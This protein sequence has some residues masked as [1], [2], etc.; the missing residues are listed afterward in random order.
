[1]TNYNSHI[2][3]YIDEVIEYLKVK[4]DGIYIDC[5]LG[6][7]GHTKKII[8][9][10]KSG[11]VIGIDRDLDA[12]NYAKSLALTNLKIIHDKFSN[13]ESIFKNNNLN[14]VDGFLFDLGV[15]S[16]QLDDPSR[17][18]SY[19]KD[20]LLDM[21]MDQTQTMT[22]RD[23]VNNYSLNQLTKIFRLY[24]ESK[25]SY[26]VAK[27]IVNA[28]KLS[29]INTT[30]QLNEIIKSSL[31]RNELIKDKHPSRV[32]F[33]AIR[34][35]VN[36]ELEEIE[37][38]VEFA[39]KHVKKGGRVVIISFHSLEN[40]LINKIIKNVS[41]HNESLSYLPTPQKISPTFKIIKHKEL[42]NKDNLRAR[43]AR[44]HIIERDY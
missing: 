32:F 36:N 23:V 31:P 30:F 5:T 20:S 7:C 37:R 12:I 14:E 13:L 25:F 8:E 44:L 43:S 17:G 42:D 28:R 2:S 6:R 4:N 39:L 22:A 26:N 38:A 24:G 3:V 18:F 1:M 33:Q 11:L 29:E 34:I 9:N 21:R 40:S 27:A 15:S 41:K 19:N 35:E 16:P 10:L